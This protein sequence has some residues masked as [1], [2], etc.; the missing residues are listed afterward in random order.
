MGVDTDCPWYIMRKN[1]SPKGPSRYEMSKWENQA[2][3]QRLAGETDRRPGYSVRSP[4]GKSG[5]GYQG[6]CAGAALPVS[7]RLL[8]CCYCQRLSE[9][10]SRQ[11]KE[12]GKNGGGGH[13]EEGFSML[14]TLCC[15]TQV[16]DTWKDGAAEISL[17]W[18]SISQSGTLNRKAQSV[19][20]VWPEA[21][22][23]IC[24]SSGKNSGLN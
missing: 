14:P 18:R 8:L 5:A 20:S 10:S 3:D 6:P 17:H 15:R 12:K 7:K 9:E 13:R 16:G 2:E 11:K 22:A 23:R 1:A 19:S 21:V 24:P 4:T